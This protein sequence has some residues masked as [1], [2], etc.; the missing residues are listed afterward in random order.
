MSKLKL[1]SMLAI[2]VGDMTDWVLDPNDEELMK[3]LA[4]E[5][6]DQYWFRDEADFG[7]ILQYLVDEAKKKRPSTKEAT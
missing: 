1:D 3:R 6:T 4:A 7:A 5:F 2:R